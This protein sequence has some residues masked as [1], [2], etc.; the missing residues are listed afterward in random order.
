YDDFENLIFVIPPK[1]TFPVSSDELSDLCYQYIYGYRNRVIEKKIPGKGWEYIVYDKQDRPVLTQDAN[2]RTL[3]RWLFTKY[4]DFDRVAYTGLFLDLNPTALTRT[5]L[6][7]LVD[8]QSALNEVQ[9][10]TVNFVG[11]WGLYYTN[12]ALQLPSATLIYDVYTV[13]YY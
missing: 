1:V 7:D 11:G 6:Q 3:N 13:N 2:L 8:S 9:Q 12:D 5:E 10:Q 4:D